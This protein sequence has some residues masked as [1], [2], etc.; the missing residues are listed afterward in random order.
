MHI[1]VYIQPCAS[2]AGG[3]VAAKE[4]RQSLFVTVTVKEGKMKEYEEVSCTI[5]HAQFH[6]DSTYKYEYLG[7]FF[8]H[9]FFPFP[10]PFFT[11]QSKPGM[12]QSTYTR[13]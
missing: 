8:S 5:R 4:G 1:R 10:H 11:T 2:Q 9:P 12:E 13:R 3:V 7:L 6:N